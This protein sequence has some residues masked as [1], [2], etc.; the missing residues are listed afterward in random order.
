MSVL[1]SDPSTAPLRLKGDVN[2]N[3]AVSALDAAVVLQSVVG[4]VSLDSHQQCAGDYNSSGAVSAFDASL[5]L[6]CVVGG[7]CRT[8][9]CN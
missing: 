3:G 9:T 4:A 8:G 7:T 2:G 5:I 6:Q 1:S